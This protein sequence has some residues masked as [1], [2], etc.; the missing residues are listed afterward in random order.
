M[1]PAPF[2]VG[3]SVI[4]G[5]AMGI[6]RAIRNKPGTVARVEPI[7]ATHA[8][9]VAVDG[10]TVPEIA[11][12]PHEL[13]RPNFATAPNTRLST[14]ERNEARRRS[15]LNMK[16]PG[17]ERTEKQ[18]Q[19]EAEGW[20]RSIGYG[21]LGVG[22]TRRQAVCYV[23]LRESGGNFKMARV[24]CPKHR[25]PVY[26][27][28]TGND[29]GVADWQVRH[30]ANWPPQ[31]VLCVEWKRDDKSRIRPE[32]AKLAE[33]GWS[34]IVDSKMDL[35]EALYRYEDELLRIPVNAWIIAALPKGETV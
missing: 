20:L 14:A 24:F 15:P 8:V 27:M 5:D 1:K 3:E 7:G 28:D 35:A 12:L 13:S 17:D 19:A 26:S 33:A 10:A 23:C 2:T 9:Y 18:K 25:T 32:Q 11:F 6:S 30:P 16:N 29:E 31:A 22:Q 21:V 34:V 4:I